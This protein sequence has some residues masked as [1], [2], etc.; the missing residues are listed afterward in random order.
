MNLKANRAHWINILAGLY[1][2]ASEVRLRRL[3]REQAEEKAAELYDRIVT[4]SK[5]LDIKAGFR[6]LELL[7]REGK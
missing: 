4:T 3:D 1:E 7:N 5:L 2:D 6:E